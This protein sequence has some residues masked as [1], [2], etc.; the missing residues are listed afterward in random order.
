MATVHSAASWRAPDARGQRRP[1]RRRDAGRGWC[2]GCGHRSIR[3]LG[4]IGRKQ[5]TAW[6]WSESGSSYDQDHATQLP[7]SF[8]TVLHVGP[9]EPRFKGTVHRLDYKSMPTWTWL[10]FGAAPNNLIL[11]EA[12]GGRC[13]DPVGMEPS[14]NENFTISDICSLVFHNASRPYPTNLHDTCLNNMYCQMLVAAGN[15]EGSCVGATPGYKHSCP[16]MSNESSN[17]REDLGFTPLGK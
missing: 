3:S 17:F 11:S 12:D 16:F 6:I 5:T 15:F 8:I 14:D 2:N 9:K 10:F 13:M 7:C 4:V 1:R